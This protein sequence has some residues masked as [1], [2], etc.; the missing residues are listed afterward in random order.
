MKK[1]F[2]NRKEALKCLFEFITCKSLWTYGT[3]F[4][5][6]IAFSGL[7]SFLHFDKTPPFPPIFFSLIV[8]SNI[9]LVL[10]ALS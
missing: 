1:L 4:I 5:V 2:K 7:A 3:P 10:W 8:V 6:L 9:A